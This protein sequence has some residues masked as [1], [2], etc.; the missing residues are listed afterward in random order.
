MIFNDLKRSVQLGLRHMK[1]SPHYERV[2]DRRI[3]AYPAAII[4]ISYLFKQDPSDPD[5]TIIR[6]YLR[7]L[8]F[9]PSALVRRTVVKC[10]GVSRMTLGPI[11]ER[12]RDVDDSVRK[13]AFKFIAEKVLDV[14]PRHFAE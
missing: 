12:T 11:L 3:A 10:I 7:H 8:K 14:A 2:R 4:I 13:A 1:C 6:A 5:C 9:D